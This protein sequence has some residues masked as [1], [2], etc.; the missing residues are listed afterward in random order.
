MFSPSVLKKDGWFVYYGIDSIGRQWDLYK[1]QDYV[2]FTKPTNVVGTY[3]TDRWRKLAENMQGDNYTFLRPLYG[4][5]ILHQWNKM[6]PDKK[7]ATLNLF[8]MSKENLP[9]YRTTAVQK[10]LY[11]VCSDN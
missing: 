3:K 5:Y 11:S 9:N 7:I 8:Y 4:K 10:N 2:D 6:H 1:N